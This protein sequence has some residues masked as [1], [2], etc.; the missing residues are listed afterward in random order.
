MQQGR[1][2]GNGAI[3]LAFIQGYGPAAIIQLAPHH[4]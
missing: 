4:A 1:R 3:E 2:T